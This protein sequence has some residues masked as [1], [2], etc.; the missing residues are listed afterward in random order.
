[1]W[2]IKKWPGRILQ[3]VLAAGQVANAGAVFYPPLIPVAIGIGLL[4]VGVGAW[5]H[6]STEEGVTMPNLAVPFTMTEVFRR[7]NAGVGGPFSVPVRAKSAVAQLLAIGGTVT[8][9]TADFEISNDGGTTWSKLQTGINV[10]AAPVRIDVSGLTGVLCR[11]NATTL[12][13]GTGTAGAI[14][15]SPSAEV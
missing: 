3:G 12:T 8:A 14:L 11:F 10:F 9:L 4:Q 1:M 6:K 15:L 7:A 5:Q 2:G 13:L